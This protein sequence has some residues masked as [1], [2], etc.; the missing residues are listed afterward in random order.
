MLHVEGGELTL[1]ARAVGDEDEAAVADAEANMGAWWPHFR[2]VV[3]VVHLTVGIIR[4]V[5]ISNTPC[6][7]LELRN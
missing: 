4:A 5:N 6:A 2:V 1:N 3:K 7:A